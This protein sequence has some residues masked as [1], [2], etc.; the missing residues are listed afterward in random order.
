MHP[1]DQFEAFRALIDDGSTPA[2]IAARFGISETAVKQRLKLARVSPV[3][4][5]AREKL[6][7]AAETVRA[8]GWKWVEVEPELN[9]EALDRF[10]LRRP[11][12]LPLSEE[13]AAEQKRLAEEYQTLFEM[14]DEED[15]AR[16]ERLDEIESRIEK[17]E[18]TER[19]FTPDTLAIA[20][21]IVSIGHDG[22]IELMRGLVRPEDEPEEATG[23]G[24]SGGKERPPFSASLIESLTACRSLVISAALMSQPK[25]ALAAVVH[26]LVAE[27]FPAFG[28]KSSLRSLR[29]SRTCTSPAKARRRWKRRATTGASACPRSRGSCGAGALPRTRRRCWSF[30]LSAR[31]M[32][33]M[34]CSARATGRK[35]HGLPT[36]ARLPLPWVSTWRSGSLPRRRITFSASD[37]RTSSPR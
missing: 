10:R 3:V 35:A 32:R 4:F 36:R 28:E 22:E 27:L 16:S 6:E 24:T 2:D 21:A 11:E 26:A 17:L 23:S 34:P 14:G 8:E 31:R 18:D 29:N 15:E 9:F 20:G 13:A 37:G 25:V 33:W 12:P 7:A 1:A 5:E 19:V 30:W